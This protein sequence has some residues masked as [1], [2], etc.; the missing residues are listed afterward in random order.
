MSL[1]WCSIL[2]ACLLLQ[3]FF[4]PGCQLIER[5]D[6]F[7]VCCYNHDVLLLGMD[8]MYSNEL[9]CIEKL[10]RL[11]KLQIIVVASTR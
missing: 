8:E 1:L 4:Y 9:V 2:L 3:F 5:N 7:V 10:C 11:V 6:A